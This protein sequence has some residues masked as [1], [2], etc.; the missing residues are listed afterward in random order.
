MKL[1][2]GLRH[3]RHI[4]S[5]SRTFT[6]FAGRHGVANGATPFSYFLFILYMVLWRYPAMAR[7]VQIERSV[8]DKSKHGFL[9]TGEV[10]TGDIAQLEKFAD[11]LGRS[12]DRY[13]KGPIPWAWIASASQLPSKALL[14]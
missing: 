10:I 2:A 8:W 5:C 4:M 3:S 14:V 7:D 12:R 11:K 1:E 6:D 13:L 9:R